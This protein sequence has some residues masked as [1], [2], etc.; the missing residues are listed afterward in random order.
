MSKKMRKTLLVVVVALLVVGAVL[1]GLGNFWTEYQ[2]FAQLSFGPVYVKVLLAQV[3]IGVAFGLFALFLLWIH[4]RMIRR[5]SQPRR[6]WAIPTPEGEIDIRQIVSKVSGPVVATGAVIVATIMGYY[7][8]GN[9]EE[10][11]KYVQRTDF[12]ETEPILGKDLGF[13]LFVLPSLQFVQ[14]WL[15]YLTALCAVLSAAVYFLRHSIEM[16]GRL[17]KMSDGVRGHLLGA[18]AC[19]LGVIALGYRVEM[20]EAL[21]SKRGVAYGATFTDVYANLIAYRVMIGACLVCAVYLLYSIRAK[22]PGKKAITHPAYALAGVGVLYLL[23]TFA[24][25]WVVQRFVVDPDELNK[26]WTFLEHAIAGTRKA[27]GLDTIERREFPAE[28]TLSYES[29]TTTHKVTLENVK[30]W[31]HRPLRATYRQLQEIRQYYSFPEIDID[32]YWVDG[33]YRQVMLAA[34]EVIHSNLQKESQTWVNKHLIY[35]H[36]YGLV[37][38]PVNVADKEGMPDLWVKDFPPKAPGRPVLA[39]KRPGIY[40]GRHTESYALVNTLE[41]EFDYPRGKEG[42]AFTTYSGK[43]GVSIGSFLSRLLFAIRFGHLDIL[44]TTRLTENSRI[45]FNRR[46]Q[47]RVHTVAP[48]LMLDQEPYM[49]IQEGRLVWLQDAYTI[50]Y[51]YPYSQPTPLGRRR[52]INYIRNSVK[53]AVDAYDGTMTFYIWDEKDP[54]IRTYAKIFPELFTPKSAMPQSLRAHVRYPKDLFNIQAHMYEAFHMIKPKDFYQKEDLWQVSPQMTEKAAGHQPAAE[55]GVGVTA[56]TVTSGTA[57]MR[58]YYMVMRLPNES[59]EEFL[60]MVPYT[61]TNKLNML[62]WLAA[63]CDGDDYG[64]VIVYT[65]PKDKL[66]YGPMQVEA[67]ISQDPEISKWITLRD[68]RGSAVI[69]GEL[70]VIPVENSL[71]YVEPFYLRS[72]QASIPE[73]KLVV[74]GFGES[75]AMGATL[76]DALRAVFKVKPAGQPSAVAKVDPPTSPLASTTTATELVS[77][78]LERYRASQDR[79]KQG[80]WAGYGAEQTSLQRVLEALGRKLGAQLQPPQPVTPAPGPHQTTPS[81]ST[82]TG[83]NPSPQVSP[84]TAVDPD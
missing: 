62:A 12:G 47:H 28:A 14:T 48:F 42:N 4:L 72:T 21:F 34:R 39:V 1:A 25:P 44:F 8:S 63:R 7:A 36:G 43:G 9:W 18:I 53:V 32:R 6:D 22:A 5:F 16:D 11:L 73:L 29:L 35:T 17:P 49:V 79:L 68:Q 37:L 83:V 57:T 67:R 75:V 30:I 38:S 24:I 54:L 52:R 56:S 84:P 2:W 71:L 64:K 61:P 66:V 50:S 3:G 70:L 55:K 81:P 40:F 26:E 27:Y 31:D 45:L 78:A 23:G 74:A 46:I 80:D 13:Y 77:R 76:E 10:V 19:V 58:P 65:F 41:K 51:R 33:E 60:L 15:L 69:R 82:K 20:F 59:R